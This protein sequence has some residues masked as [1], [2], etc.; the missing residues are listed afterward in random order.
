MPR[1]S[2]AELYRLFCDI[3]EGG[4]SSE[5]LAQFER[6]THEHAEV[7]QLYV[8]FAVVCG[9]LRYRHVSPGR[10]TAAVEAVPTLPPIA[11][12]GNPGRLGAAIQSTV[13][14]FSSGWPVAYLIATVIFGIGLLV[15][16][17]VHV[18]RPPQV[19]VPS[20]PDPSPIL[21]S[22][23]VESVGR[24]TA[25]VDCQWAEPSTEPVDGAYVPL[26]RK[27]ALASG[28]MEIT[29]DSGARVI[30]Q[31][32][33][34]YEVESAA[35][36]YLSVGKLTAKLEK[37]SEVR[38]QKPEFANQKSEI[39]N[40]KSPDLWP[41]AS[42][43]F[44]VRTPTAVVTDLGTEFGVEVAK[45]GNTQSHVFRGSVK[46]QLLGAGA[47]N[48]S[49]T[50]VLRENESVQTQPDADAAKPSVRLI[51]VN[52]DPRIF[53]RRITLPI[54]TLD[55]RDIVAGGDGRVQRRARRLDPINGFEETVLTLEPGAGHKPRRIGSAD[56]LIDRIF[57]PDGNQGRVSLDSAEHT[58]DG[59]PRTKGKVDG[60]ICATAAGTAPND[61]PKLNKGGQISLRSH[62]GI[63]FDLG[64][65]RERYAGTRPT[66]LRASVFCG[67]STGVSTLFQDDFQSDKAGTMPRD[68]NSVLMPVIGR[69]DVGGRWSYGLADSTLV[70]VWNNLDPSKLNG[71]AGTNRYV[72]V[73]R[74]AM[75]HDGNLWAKGW[76][77]DATAGKQVELSFS[78]WKDPASP[79][80]AAVDAFTNESFGGRTFNA[81]FF[82][83]GSVWCYDG[84]DSVD[85]GLSYRTG[86]WQNITIRANMATQTFSLTV[87]GATAEN[88]RWFSGTN[89]VSH[90]LFSNGVAPA[91]RFFIDNVK[92]TASAGLAEL[93]R[94][95]FG[96][97]GQGDFWVFVD[98]RLK[99][100]RMGLQPKDG[101][102]PVDIEIGPEDRFLTLV[103]VGDGTETQPNWVIWANPMLEMVSKA[104]EPERQK[105]RALNDGPH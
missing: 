28:L 18:S 17:L 99:L 39:I 11:P 104:A 83:N 55:L 35:G 67:S 90:I 76:A 62:A 42:D 70:Q 21:I 38:G 1:P 95:G 64:A 43:L 26:G 88:L 34:T 69:G 73:Q 80:N 61:T 93:H 41:L 46:V 105:R 36:G 77:S 49:N 71:D 84:T 59:F 6:L 101:A 81:Y 74:D 10:T 44:A 97:A 75:G 57:L 14:V 85:T 68:V 91:G 48:Q 96:T 87:N 37:K 32:P 78:I 52:S 13:G 7:R 23:P 22:R 50:V 54:K 86:V 15:G 66:R 63:T 65:I 56:K 79:T 20:T 94:R 53:T 29:Y 98:G 19:A 8:R 24:I 82:P 102:V 58:F 33:V 40:H 47:E 31:G 2:N 51:R 30:L 72:K 89:V 3:R 60:A 4:C 103:A 45:D 5:D 92:L 100:N 25:I 16:A 27:Y 9:M 12:A